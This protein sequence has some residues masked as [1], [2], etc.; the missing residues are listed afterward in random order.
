MHEGH[1]A[2]A[3]RAVRH[4]RQ[5][6]VFLIGS[7]SHFPNGALHDAHPTP[8]AGMVVNR[9]A[10]RPQ[11]ST[12]PQPL[13]SG[14]TTHLYRPGFQHS[15]MS[16]N[17]S[18]SVAIRFL[19]AAARSGGQGDN[20]TLIRRTR[21]PPPHSGTYCTPSSHQKIGNAPI[22][23]LTC[24]RPCTARGKSHAAAQR[25][26]PSCRKTPATR[27]QASAPHHARKQFANA[28]LRG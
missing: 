20:D 8:V 22:R 15:S 4:D 26:H 16:V 21:G 23:P 1:A 13:H 27:A 24:R 10:S 14:S 12:C 25:L 28:L 7:I 18:S 19:A 17:V 9:A 6:A 11:S 5:R 3:Q 2:R